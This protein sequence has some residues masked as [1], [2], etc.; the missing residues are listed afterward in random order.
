M[1]LAA[2][3][4]I[5]WGSRRLDIAILGLFVAP[6]WVGVY[7]VAQQVA[8]LPQ[9]LKTSFDPILAPVITQKLAEGDKQAVAKQ[10]R[11]VGFWIIAAQAAI[12]LALGIPGEAVMGLVGAGLRRRH[13][14]AR[15]PAR[16]R[17]GRGDRGGLG[18]RAGLCRAPPQPDDLAADDRRPGGAD[19]R[20]SSSAL[21]AARWP[22][23][24]ICARPSRRPAPRS[25][26]VLALG[27]ASILK[28]RLL[29]PPARRAGAGLA[30]AAGLGGGGGD[31][32]SATASPRCRR[33]SNGPSWRS[34]SPLILLAFGMVVWLRGFTH[35]DR[36]LFRLQKDEEPTLPPPGAASP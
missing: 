34:A 21:D 20:R 35:E 19:R 4:A 27:L 28:A 9:K 33:R 11:Q 30:L 25:R 6:Y 14:R 1:P 15:L 24:E 22:A 8:S 16:R 10:V 2:A 23:D 29:V 3:D 12:A 36:V 5:E 13:R 7:Y 17:G 32:W 31:R 18:S 26:S